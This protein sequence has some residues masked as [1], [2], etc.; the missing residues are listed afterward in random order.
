M[1][2]WILA[3]AL[4]TVPVA[5]AQPT[6]ADLLFE[7]FDRYVEALRTQ[8][9]IPGLAAVIVGENDILWER[10]AGL[11]D[12]E[13]AIPARS[14]TPFQ[15]D[16]LTQL[17]TATLVLQCAEQGGVSLDAPISAFDTGTTDGNATIA[18]ILT[19]TSGSPLSPLVAY[20]PERIEWLKSVVRACTGDSFRETVA[21]QLDRLAMRDSVPGA[22]VVYLAP[23]AE[24]VPEATQ[25]DRYKAVL[26]RLATSYIVRRPGQ[27]IATAHPAKTLSATAGL[28]STVRDLAQF[29][30]A[31]RKGLL[32]RPDTLALAWS[33]P[34][35]ADALAARH[36]LGWFVQTY[37][38]ETI[39]WQFGVSEASS[40]LVVTVPGRGLTLILL[41][42][43]DG[44]VAP[45]PL[46]AGDVTISPF[47]RVFLSVAIP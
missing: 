1:R 4:A 26:E 32:V 14:D 18:Q 23:P 40:S 6:P 33:A 10:A 5:A 36:G 47:A 19:H 25:V 13:R 28:I 31:L 8:A 38:G 42:N 43:S 9:G 35:A 3:V 11:Q 27:A 34:P 17:V 16:G 15:I 46:S 45:F 2:P 30:L 44:L 20:R 21:N 7:R 22:D 12:V 37:K 24:G 39:V 29:D 41:A